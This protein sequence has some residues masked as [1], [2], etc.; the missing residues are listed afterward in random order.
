MRGVLVVKSALAAERASGVMPSA[1]V[2]AT[3]RGRRIQK[4]PIVLALLG[5]KAQ[6]ESTDQEAWSSIFTDG[7]PADHNVRPNAGGY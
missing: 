2:S 7:E 1:N 5:R 3:A 4:L 6:L